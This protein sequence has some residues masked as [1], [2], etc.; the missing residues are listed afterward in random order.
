M[1]LIFLQLNLFK[2]KKMGMILAFALDHCARIKLDKI[3]TVYCKALAQS[4]DS[5]TR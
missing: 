3:W 4:E 1:Y 2:Y 5:N